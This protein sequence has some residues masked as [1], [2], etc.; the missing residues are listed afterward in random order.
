M[1]RQEFSV[2]YH[3]EKRVGDHTMDVQFLAPALLAFGKL[4]REANTELNRKKSTSKVLVISDFEHKCF[5]VNFQLVLGFY[6]QLKALVY[7][8]QAR[9]AK[10]ILE[11]VGLI[12]GP[13]LG[14]GLSL[15]GFLR[16]KNGRKTK[17]TILTDADATGSVQVTVP[18]ESASVTINTTIYNLA[19][20]PTA[21]KAARDALAPIG[22]DGF[23]AMNIAIKDS[24]EPFVIGKEDAERIISSCNQ[25]I[26]E[27]KL[28]LRQISQKS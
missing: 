11:W 16:W 4:L 25:G 26:E 27:A 28:S 22:Q 14:A 8:E 13:P 2:S 19:Q 21:L 20:N 18:G 3:G 10:E 6:E 9:S 1:S 24:K 12:G 5:N 15:L 17:A 23:D 7:T